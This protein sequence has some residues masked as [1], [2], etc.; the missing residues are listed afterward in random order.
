M[1]ATTIHP[2]TSAGP[3]A[4]RGRRGALATGAA[5]VAA[6]FAVA[7]SGCGVGVGG[8]GTGE[9][10]EPFGATPSSVCA[11]PVAAALACGGAATAPP[12]EGSARTRFVDTAG[13]GRVRVTINGNQIDFDAVC[14]GLRFAGTWGTG[15][16]GRTRYF[17]N[18]VRSTDGVTQLAV[19]EVALAANG[20]AQNLLAMLKDANDRSLLP[21]VT[22]RPVTEL[23]TTPP[24]CPA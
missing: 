11:G 18:V 12:S 22:L 16:D 1:T 14:A 15:R 4:R 6:A 10:L 9:D 21:T 8:T 17:G 19:I 13:N 3:A 5:A 7:L 2:T 24:S 20:T 23:P